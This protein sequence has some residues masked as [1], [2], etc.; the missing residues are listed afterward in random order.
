MLILD[1]SSTVLYDA[2]G[3]LCRVSTNLTE[4]I[5][6]RFPRDSRMDFEKNPRD[7]YIALAG[8]VMNRIYFCDIVWLNIEQKHDMHY[9]QHGAIAK[10]K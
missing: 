6:R 5:S 3:I 7:I 8:Y 4:Q 2:R 10:I 1:A 9:I